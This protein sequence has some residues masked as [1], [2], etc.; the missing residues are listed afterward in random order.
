MHILKSKINSVS[1]VK[2]LVVSFMLLIGVFL[3]VMIY[4][5]YF[6]SSIRNKHIYLENYVMARNRILTAVQSD[7]VR[8]SN[9]ISTTF[10]NSDWLE[11]AGTTDVIRL[12]Y[13]ID[14]IVLGI[15][16]LGDDYLRYMGDDIFVDG[17]IHGVRDI[18]TDRMLLI[19][20]KVNDLYNYYRLGVD[21]FNLP[22]S[23]YFS[24]VTYKFTTPTVY[25]LEYLR[26]INLDVIT[27]VGAYLSNQ[28]DRYFW[29]NLYALILTI[30]IALIMFWF[31][32]SSLNK[33]MSLFEMRAKAIK[34]GNFDIDIYDEGKDEI[35]KLS[36][37]MADVVDT[38]R[39]LINQ[40]NRVSNEVS[41][42][43]TESCIDKSKF[44]G[45]YLETAVAIDALA[46]EVKSAT[47]LK[48]E[49][50]YYEYIQFMM[51][52]VPV[53][54][55][56][57]SEDFKLIGCNDEV[58]RRY[59]IE[60]KDK[61]LKNFFLFSPETQP[62]GTPSIEKAREHLAKAVCSSYIKFDWVHQDAEGNLIPS[63]V[64]CYKGKFM[65]ND[66]IFTY[67]TDMRDFYKAVEE[68]KR[69]GIAEENAKAKSRFLARM[70]HEIRTPISAVLG[71][72]EIQ[73]QDPSL[74]MAVEEAFAKI[75]NSSQILLRIINDILDL[76]KI[77][78]DKMEILNEEYEMS[79]LIND[80]IQLN[81]FRMGSKE[82]KFNIDI[83]ENVPEVM[84][85]DELR[86]KQVMNNLLSN[87]FKY[88]EKG[89]VN[90]TV[91][92]LEG[93]G[94]SRLHF[95]I[96]DS[97]CGMAET[98]LEYLFQEFARFNLEKNQFIEGIGLG[99]SI[100]NSLLQ[101]MGGTIVVESKVNV[102]TTFKVDIPQKRVS[103]NNI[104]KDLI[105][106]LVNFRLTNR[107]SAKKLIFT[108]DPMPYGKV[109]VVDDV[110]TNLYVAKG[111]LSF[112]GLDI[113]TCDS[114][115]EAL[116]LIKSGKVY[117]II[118]LDQMM[119]GMDGVE[120]IRHIRAEGYNHPI[121]ALTANALIGQ[122]E[123]FLKNGFDGFISKPID[124]SRLNTILNKF[125][126]DKQPI[127]I[128]EAARKNAED[129]NRNRKDK[130]GAWEFFTGHTEKD[131]S[132]EFFE[133]IRIDFAK[134]QKNVITD[135][136]SA[137]EKGDPV[138]CRR[139][140]HTLKGL[141][142]T[143]KENDLAHTAAEL[144]DLF[145]GNNS[146][147]EVTQ[148]INTL[149]TNLKQ[150]LEGIP[151]GDSNPLQE[152]VENKDLDIPEILEELELLMKDD[153]ADALKTAERLRNIPQAAVLLKQV[154]DFD[155]EG[156]L[157]TLH[158]L[159]EVIT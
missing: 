109:L 151:K 152:D 63:E 7:F 67:A 147:E 115:Y 96:A 76:S 77:E 59:K 68:A 44:V 125:I 10:N 141:A 114:G 103:K 144:E 12:Q 105:D 123:V 31:T 111:I 53:V 74:P 92:F 113:E 134:S 62:D 19:L 149:E 86:I 100:V 35:A 71:I 16:N 158:I 64:T 50:Q 131:A 23:T 1:I 39:N 29:F 47:Y 17:I 48:A 54:I 8:L 75:Y 3:V 32:V 106:S 38:F 70:S 43:S 99:M 42:G 37:I 101:L 57:W 55:S 120:T 140:A 119:P 95:V 18:A 94:D 136:R 108:P 118:F 129:S 135:I 137:L 145:E 69:S 11:S 83:D 6:T 84:K 127:E 110:E 93:G 102:G 98:D 154:G 117:D 72:S 142:R 88:T 148:L 124:T 26:E 82:I 81:V 14:T 13:E 78:A 28:Q 52:T 9:V 133:S 56:F 80:V 107:F 2:K 58:L 60:D 159:K 91:K 153:S 66:V 87:A 21:P 15:Q 126:R 36:N 122:S 150:V 46:E 146:G 41:L 121:V 61:Y 85:G 45:S 33:R 22:E 5:T 40:I 51:D 143:I 89:F 116:N 157:R 155:F 20:A 138:S 24:N 90:M 65:G 139:F 112:Y 25:M 34:Q 156:A 4:S 130:G 128:V 73:L 30:A 49:T 97:G 27:A 132:N 79:S 104:G